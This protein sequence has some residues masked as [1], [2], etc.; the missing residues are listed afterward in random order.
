MSYEIFNKE[1]IWNKRGKPPV[2]RISKNGHIRF[3]GVAVDILG[4]TLETKIS[5][6]VD[7]RD[8]DL[9]YFYVDAEKG[10]PLGMVNKT[11]K[12]N[13]Y[14]ICCRGLAIKLLKFIGSSGN[15]TFDITTDKCETPHG[16]MWFVRKDKIHKPIKW[17]KQELKIA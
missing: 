17:R 16:S 7:A 11:I 2:L 3:S 1:T 10:M 9:I 4:L 6:M 8:K 13:G 5:F 15:V 12:G 14:Q